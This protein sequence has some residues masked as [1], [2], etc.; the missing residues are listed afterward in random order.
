MFTL[1]R[2]FRFKFGLRS[3]T[4]TLCTGNELQPAMELQFEGLEFTIESRPRS[5]SHSF[6]LALGTLRL[7]DLLTID[8]LFP[9][10]V[11]ER[12]EKTSM[13][14][15]NHEPLFQL[16]YEVL[17]KSGRKLRIRSRPLEVVYHPEA[18][19][20]LV[21]FAC[22]P[23]QLAAAT[24]GL[25]IVKARTKQKL[26]R[27][28]E[29]IVE[30]SDIDRVLPTWDVQLD[31]SAPQVIFTES[32]CN[33]NAI[34]AV[35]DLG[36]LH[37]T[38]VEDAQ[39][40]TTKVAVETLAL[41]DDEEDEEFATPCSTPPGSEASRSGTETMSTAVTEPTSIANLLNEA[42][43]ETAFHSRL[44][45][46]YTAELTDLQ[47][48]TCRVR[49]GWR[50]AHTR[51]SSSM[52]VLERFSISATCERRL[53][54]TQDPMYPAVA[55]SAQLPRFVLHVNE[56]KIAAARTLISVLSSKTIEKNISESSKI[57]EAN[58]QRV[59]TTSKET[60][61]EDTQASRLLMV[62]F[63][64]E[65]ASVQVQ[66]R[67][68]SIAELQVMGAS[69]TLT[70]RP[71][72]TSVTLTVHGLLLV[73]ALQTYGPDFELLVASHRHVGMDSV[74]G[75]LRDSEPV[76]PTSPASPDPSFHPQVR[77]LL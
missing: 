67:G 55:L 21:E 59:D 5:N 46:R 49:D 54:R 29:N 22:G 11:C 77:F 62:Q 65:H 76:S 44:Y 45:E 31:I 25:E 41:D 6:E 47:V 75:S 37:V 56:S 53:I 61:L 2:Y 30:G 63:T 28:W 48:L 15:V 24:H 60:L 12:G 72:D 3:G 42:L 20:W 74:S 38:N 57:S 39:A 14:E 71:C 70:R 43:S 33:N 66:S 16:R 52:H 7:R 9:S 40:V 13:M 17:P 10:L 1:S 8:T 18:A 4:L 51:G 27:N 68:R 64:V 23:Q 35:V 34:I 50:H 26:M 69:A 19:K 32:F 58:V 36:R 73:D